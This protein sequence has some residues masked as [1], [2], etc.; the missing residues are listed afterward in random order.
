MPTSE[1]KGGVDVGVKQVI[2]LAMGETRKLCPWDLKCNVYSVN[3][4]YRQI[5]Q[6]DGYISKLFCCHTQ[7]WYQV[8][9][10]PI[11]N[12]DEMN[13]LADAGVDIIET[14]R[15]KGLKARLY[16]FKRIVKKFDTEFFSDTIC[17]MLAYAIDEWTYV[18]KKDFNRVKLREPGKKHIIH[19]YGVDMLTFG[20]YQLEKGGVEFWCGI[21]RGLGI[22]V[23]IPKY[24]SVCKTCTGFP[25][26]KKYFSMNDIDPHKL[27]KLKDDIIQGKDIPDRLDLTTQGEGKLRTHAPRPK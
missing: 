3:N 1:V 10:T 18:D 5:A 13:M 16:P 27:A 7:C 11:Y 26:G 24:S 19:M 23:V 15:V 6:M 14:H 9:N 12:W 22:E 2:I 20:E 17:Y 21:A 4:G 8:D 25:Y